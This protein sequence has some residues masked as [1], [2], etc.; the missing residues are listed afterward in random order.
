MTKKAEAMMLSLGEMVRDCLADG[1]DGWGFALVCIHK[2]G[3][4]G[5]VHNMGT[6]EQAKCVIDERLAVHDRQDQ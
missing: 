5:I 2:N 6:N 4:A 1:S 3:F